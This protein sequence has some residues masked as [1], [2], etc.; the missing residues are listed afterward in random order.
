M[1]IGISLQ[2]LLVLNRNCKVK[3]RNID[4]VTNITSQFVEYCSYSGHIYILESRGEVWWRGSDQCHWCLQDIL[5]EI[6]PGLETL[7][8]KDTNRLLLISFIELVLS[9]EEHPKQYT[10]GHKMLGLIN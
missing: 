9:S 8:G 2:Y 6:L 5:E 1:W 7:M 3:F 10:K 4:T